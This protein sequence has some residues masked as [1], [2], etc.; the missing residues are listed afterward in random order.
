VEGR[1][2]LE[3]ESPR[4]L[5]EL[6]GAAVDLYFRVPILFLVLAAIAVVPWELIVWLIT[7]DGPLALGRHG[8]IVGQL[9][10]LADYFFVTPLI[11]AFHVHAV[12]QFGDGDQPRL[13]ATLRRSLPTL[14]V[15]VLVTGITGF[16]TTIGF[17][18]L[19]VPGLLL[20]ARWAV[21]SQTA[22][23]EGGGWTDA[24]RRGTD[25]TD[26]HRWDVFWVIFVTGLIVAVP[27]IVARVFF[28]HT[29]TTAASF[30]VGTAVQVFMR[31]FGALVLALLYF[32]LKGRRSAAPV[33]PVEAA[34]ADEGRAAGWYVDPG[35]PRRMRYWNADGK[36]TWSKTTAKTPKPVRREWEEGHQGVAAATA[37]DEEEQATGHALDPGVYSDEERPPGWYVDPDSPWQMRYW[38]A[39]GEPGWSRTTTKTPKQVLANWR[40][41]RWQR[42]K[43]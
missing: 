5:T 36:G 34:P 29:T 31:S 37:T 32:D 7:G 23:L 8:F 35:N 18:L 41:L 38:N 15:V 40:D 16:A 24:L 42:G 25:L 1:D 27:W 19:V 10:G 4:S 22:A 17:A 28:G 26:G 21:V 14:P 3:L 11:A 6:I 43:S 9:V 12:R 20:L 30:A 39:E 33:E 2:D 13:F